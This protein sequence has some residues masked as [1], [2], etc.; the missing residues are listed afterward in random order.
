MRLGFC[1]ALLA[2]I[3]LAQNPDPEELFRRAV[4]AQQRGDYAAAIGDYQRLLLMRP[5]FFEALANLGASLVHEGRFD[6]AIADYRAALK[7]RPGDNAVERNLGLALY[8]KGDFSNAA[9]QFDSLHKAQPDDVSLAT[10]LGDCYVRLGQNDRAVAV[11]TPLE[12]GNPENLD[13][14][15]VLGSAMVHNGKRREG[16]LLLD[17][18]ARGGNSVDAYMLAGSTWL[19]LNEFEQARQ[20]LDTAL[21]LN[22]NLP[23]L[24]TLSGIVRD[25]M[26]DPKGAE[27]ELRKALEMDSADFQ[28][29]LNLGAIL[30]KER[31]MDAAK[32]YLERAAA[33]NPA[34]TLARYEL[35][36]LRSTSGQ[37]NAAV[38]DLEAI[39][40]M[41]PNWLEPHVQLAALYYKLHREA[42]GL[43]ERQIVDRLTSEQPKRGPES[44]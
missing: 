17:R 3:S 20:D 31:E 26:G 44:R 43:R 33:L 15:Y 36:L 12:R 34:S 28:A 27:P 29:N 35:A 24:H 1:V 39:T 40:R 7:V 38:Q 41:D 10:L 19:D 8:K 13:L 23:G 32:R 37:V 21:R 11:L 30:Y 5:D 18:V 4:D 25:K 9:Q 14:L 2:S 16:A 42:D 6:D 22:P